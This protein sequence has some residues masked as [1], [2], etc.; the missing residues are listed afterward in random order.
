MIPR[1]GRGFPPPYTNSGWGQID[2]SRGQFWL[3][4][5]FFLGKIITDG[6]AASRIS[7]TCVVIVPQGSL[8]PQRDCGMCG[9]WSVSLTQKQLENETN[10]IYRDGGIVKSHELEWG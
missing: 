10:K 6:K 1:K 7:R 9:I 4:G 8:D 3:V 2:F 5:I